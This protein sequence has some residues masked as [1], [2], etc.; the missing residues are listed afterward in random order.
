MPLRLPRWRR[1]P[2]R[3]FRIADVQPAIPAYLR[4]VGD[5]GRKRGDSVEQQSRWPNRSLAFPNNYRIYWL[6]NPHGGCSV[7]CSMSGRSEPMRVAV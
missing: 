4:G 5:S 6:Q 2:L 3:P 1:S 7:S